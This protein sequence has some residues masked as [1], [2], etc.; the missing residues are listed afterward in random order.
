MLNGIFDLANNKGKHKKLINLML[1]FALFSLST[2]VH[3]VP[4][5]L[6]SLFTFL[7][8]FVNHFLR[9]TLQSIRGVHYIHTH[10]LDLAYSINHR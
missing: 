5:V 3:W 2:S 4:L 8:V 6:F 1:K 9:S 7:S 10:V